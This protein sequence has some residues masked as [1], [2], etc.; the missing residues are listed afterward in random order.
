MINGYVPTVKGFFSTINGDVSWVN[1]N[2]ARNN[3][4]SNFYD[5]T[6]NFMPFYLSLHRK[7]FYRSS[8]LMEGGK[9][10]QHRASYFLTGRFSRLNA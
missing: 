9:S 5:T 8:S 7:L 3:E 10:G 1:G 2:D 4:I 6:E